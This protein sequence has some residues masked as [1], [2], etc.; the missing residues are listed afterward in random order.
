MW[1]PFNEC[2]NIL[3]TKNIT[4]TGVLHVGAHICEEFRDYVYNGIP[5]DNI[6]WIEANSDLVNKMKS[7]GVRNIHCF[8]ADKEEGYANF[9]ITNNGE[10]SSLLKLGTHKESYPFVNVIKTVTVEK[11]KLSTWFNESIPIYGDINLKKLNFWNLDIQGSEL[12]AVKS[13][14]QYLKYADAIYTEINTEYVY[15]NCSL[16]SEMDTFLKEHGFEREIIAM[17]NAG[18]GDCLYVR[19]K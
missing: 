18:W 15:E 7:H 17:T 1:I 12:N 5:V 10:S 6:H 19:V 2:V 4:P 11:K 3:K 8:A 14:E 9:Y 16:L 13:A